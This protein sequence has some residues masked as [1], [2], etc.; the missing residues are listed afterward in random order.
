MVQWKHSIGGVDMQFNQDL[1]IFHKKFVIDQDLSTDQGIVDIL[2][3]AMITSTEHDHHLKKYY[4]NDL[5]SE[6]GIWVLTQYHIEISQLPQSGDQIIIETRVIQ[7][8]NL[9]VVRYFRILLEDRLLMEIFT[10]FVGID[11][12]NRKVMRLESKS[13]KE[14]GIIDGAYKIKF[15]KIN[16]PETIE[17]K[18]S[19]SYAIQ[20]TDI[21]IN[22]HVNNLVYIR[23]CFSSIEDREL[24]NRLPMEI[25]VKYG[26]EILPEQHVKI[27]S[28]FV[29]SPDDT[30]AYFKIQNTVTDQEASRIMIKWKN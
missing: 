1:G 29:S 3:K 21:D 17:G 15:S 27:F 19:M 9:F 30:Q 13:I 14:L 8:N 23:W 16:L 24:K 10:Q 7:A 4:L 6:N 12:Q 20:M 26:K 18:E 2:G 5:I 28:D 11:Y 25:D 22:A